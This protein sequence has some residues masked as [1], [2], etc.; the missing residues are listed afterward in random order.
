MIDIGALLGALLRLNRDVDQTRR[1]GAI[2]G[3]RSWQ[4]A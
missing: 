1:T 4:R 3:R 2:T